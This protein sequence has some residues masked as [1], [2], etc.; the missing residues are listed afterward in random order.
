VS[1]IP[2][3]QGTLGGGGWWTRRAGSRYQVHPV[4][5]RGIAGGAVPC[6]LVV[7]G[8]AVGQ[9]AGERVGSG[10]SGEGG[11]GRGEEKRREEGEAINDGGVHR[12]QCPA[13]STIS[14]NTRP[15]IEK[16]AS[17]MNDGQC[18]PPAVYRTVYR[19]SEYAQ[20]GKPKRFRPH[21]YGCDDA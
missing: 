9:L 17:R 7:R 8:G 6:A 4:P 10:G 16:V 1:L 21:H 5:T 3:L 13:L 2:F 15:R 20:D 12:R 11:S 18:A 19:I 14:P